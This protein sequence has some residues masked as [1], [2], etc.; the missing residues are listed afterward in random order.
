MIYLG[1]DPGKRGAIASIGDLGGTAE[2]EAVPLLTVGDARPEYDLGR[3][4]DRLAAWRGMVALAMVEH[5]DPLPARVR[6][7]DGAVRELGGGFANYARGESK[8]WA[9][10]LTALRIPFQLV[11]PQQW[12]RAMLAG[13][14]KASDTK[15]RSIMAAQRLFPAVSLLPTPRS[16][17]PSDGFADALLL[18]EYARRVHSGG[19]L[20]AAAE[21]RAQTSAGVAGPEDVFA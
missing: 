14:P 10:M 21:R 11:R 4:A 5:L 13:T 19:E 8:G 15:T 18:A 2:V 1:I 9:W 3:I 12:Q 20:F 7:K 17:K 16:R 6:G